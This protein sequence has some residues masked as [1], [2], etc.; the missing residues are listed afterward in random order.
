MQSATC[1][2]VE[3]EHQ[4]TA[5]EGAI[6]DVRLPRCPPKKTCSYN[7][8]NEPIPY[9]PAGMEGLQCTPTL[10]KLELLRYLGDGG[11]NPSSV[12]HALPISHYFV[13]LKL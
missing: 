13:R 6:K 4:N 10:G 7:L 11:K 1:G 9:H 2:H 8:I 3:Q 12:Y 5:S